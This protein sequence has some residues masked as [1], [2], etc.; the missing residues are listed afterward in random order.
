MFVFVFL[1]FC[2]WGVSKNPSL[3]TMFLRFSPV[4]S[5]KGFVVLAV[6]LNSTYV[7]LIFV[8]SMMWCEVGVQ[9][10]SFM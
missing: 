7:E 5:F 9:C 6:T 8:Y 2:F 3:N 10:H 1:S 4:F